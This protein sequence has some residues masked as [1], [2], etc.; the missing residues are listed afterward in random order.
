MK[1]LSVLKLDSAW[2]PVAMI[3]LKKAVKY[4]QKNKVLSEIGESIY[5]LKG[6]FNKHLGEDSCTSIKPIIV[7]KGRLWEG[8]GVRRVATLSNELLFKRDNYTCAYCGKVFAFKDLSRDHIIPR[9]QKGSDTWQNC[10]SACK[11][12]NHKKANK[13]PQQAGMQLRYEPFVPSYLDVFLYAGNV[14]PEQKE[15]LN[16]LK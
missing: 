10:V 15:F 9:H 16:S 7:I 8:K 5:T 11:P 3:P 6:G 1:N 2:R 4:Y 12:C 14:L 13:T